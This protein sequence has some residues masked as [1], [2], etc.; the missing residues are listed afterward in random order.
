[1]SKKDP[2]KYPGHLNRVVDGDT[3]YAMLDLGFHVK[4]VVPVRLYGI[5]CPE[6]FTEAGKKATKAVKFLLG[7]ANLEF[8]SHG[9]GKYGRW[10]CEVF[11]VL[12]DGT[13]INVSDHLVVNGHAVQVSYRDIL[14]RSGSPDEEEDPKDTEY[15][16]STVE[17][18][19][20]K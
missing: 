7:G 4:L 20:Q 15:V 14:W 8:L 2:R 12:E 11:V 1:V 16:L 6:R 19:E 10:V 18:S 17:V 5:N 13:H 9:R 3:I